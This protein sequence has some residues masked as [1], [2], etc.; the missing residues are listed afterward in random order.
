MEDV[1]WTETANPDAGDV[2][3]RDTLYLLKYV[4]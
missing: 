4:T 3:K 1:D 2:L